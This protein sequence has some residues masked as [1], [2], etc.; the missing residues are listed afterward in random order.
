MIIALQ[1]YAGDLERTMSLARLLA[2][3]EPAPRADVV[4]ALVCQPGTPVTSLVEKTLVHCSRKFPVEHVV[5]PLGAEGHPEGCTFLWAGT[6]Q[7]YYGKYRR[8][9][10]SHESIMT[11]DGVDGVPLHLGWVDMV[12]AEHAETL[13]RESSSRDLPTGL[14]DARFT[15]TRTRSSNSVSWIRRHS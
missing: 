1:Y 4:L 9:E 13:A 14:A 6:M 7:H 15:S 10:T 5:S 11:L 8:G 3:V 2:D 12:L